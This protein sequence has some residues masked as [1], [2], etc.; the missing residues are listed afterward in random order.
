MP[1][2]TM[3]PLRATLPTGRVTLRRTQPEFNAV[4]QDDLSVVAETTTTPKVGKQAGA[5]HLPASETAVRKGGTA[6]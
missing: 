6:R 1:T 2:V 3:V 5:V 4:R